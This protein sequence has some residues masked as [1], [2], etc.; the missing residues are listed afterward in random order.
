MTTPPTLNL[1]QCFDSIV[2]NYFPSSDKN[3]TEQKNTV[4][5][6]YYILTINVL[7]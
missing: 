5:Q 6:I 7:V 4:L 3:K 1:L 2:V